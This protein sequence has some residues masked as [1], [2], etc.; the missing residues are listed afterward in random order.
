MKLFWAVVFYAGV[1]VCLWPLYVNATRVVTYV[2]MAAGADRLLRIP[3]AG[4]L[5]AAAMAV[6]IM[7]AIGAAIYL[8]RKNQVAVAWLV[9]LLAL[10]PMLSRL[11]LSAA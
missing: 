11:A 4:V 10:A 5:V 7:W 6:L 3:P 2:Q 1:A 9:V 8:Y